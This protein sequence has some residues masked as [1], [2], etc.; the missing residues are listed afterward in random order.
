MSTDYIL[1]IE[2]L[3]EKKVPIDTFYM[4]DEVK[5]IF[6]SI[7]NKTGGKSKYLSTNSNALRELLG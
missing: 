6:E 2:Q 1:E 3:I 4:V 7:A 5:D